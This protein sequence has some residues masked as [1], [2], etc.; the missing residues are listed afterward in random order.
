MLLCALTVAAFVTQSAAASAQ[1]VAQIRSS[2]A[3]ALPLLQRSAATFVARRSCFSCHHNALPILTLRL[4][5]SR[6]L[7]VDAAVLASVEEKTFRGLSGPRAL[8]D[9]VQAA[10][11][12]DP[13]PNTS[14][15]LMAAQAADIEP[16]LAMNVSANRI[17]A[18]QRDGHWITSDFRPPHS[19]SQ[20]TA[21][22]TAVRAIRRYMPVER[23]AERD[24]AIRKARTWLLAARPASTEDAAFRLM[25]LVWAEAPQDAVE[26]AGRDLAALENTA[27]GWPQLPGYPADAYSTGEALFA[28][29][30]SGAPTT[31]PA[32]RAGLRFLISTQAADGTWRVRTRM[33]SPA[34]VSPPYFRTG[35]PYQKDEFLSYAG[36]SW[37]VMALAA[38]LP[39]TSVRQA[40]AKTAVVE[41]P[42]WA[43]IALFGSTEQLS[44]LLDGGL[45]PNGQAPNG[46][47]VLMMAALD[48][49]KV[50]LLAARGAQPRVRTGSGIDALAVAASYGGTAAS[51]RA[52][53]D[54]GAQAQPP[55]GTR[56]KHSP[57]AFAAMT[58][59][60]ASVQLLLAHGADPKADTSLSEGVT[61]G[62]PEVVRAL[63]AAGASVKVAES[64]GINLLH[65]ATIANR[66]AVIPVLVA[67][68]VPL[69]ATDERGFTPLM[70]AATIDFG[71]DEVMKA[72]LAA[73]ADRTVRNAEGRTPLEQARRFKHQ[74]L[75]DALRSAEVER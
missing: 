75:E 16:N 56:L 69:N 39:S 31:H 12:S 17:A 30:E 14:Y 74:R 8:D 47:T 13:T 55:P 68:G 1:S 62:H 3:R 11:L 67:A 10:T 15:L 19:S 53:I 7:E 64:S 5:R 44:A 63:V 2:A 4:A 65:W 45:D 25:G 66:P 58:G 43:R 49:A 20:F 37:A 48:A 29:R 70:Y 34:E 60:L 54:A 42:S 6:G 28:L 9:A 52:L 46:T 59:D 61:F 40:P 22:A 57:L 38:M 23:G 71:D 24:E 41:S 33:L 73:G 18:W 35:F 21:T 26:G 27:G 32:V 50:R 51:L 36:S 72:L